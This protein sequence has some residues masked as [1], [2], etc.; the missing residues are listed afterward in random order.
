MKDSTC[1]MDIL[2]SFDLYQSYNQAARECHC[3]PNTV[4]AL[5]LARKEGTLAKRGLR[6]VASSVFDADHR[7]L[8]AELVDTSEG[9]IRANVVHKRLLALE[10]RGSKRTTWRAVHRERSRWTRANARVYWPWIPEPGKWAQYDFSLWA[11]DKRHEDIHTEFCQVLP[12]C[13]I[14]SS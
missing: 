13:G 3:S 7:C 14:A 10:Y 2:E 9:R 8:I 6:Q 12:I 1:A 4:K 11:G 5:V